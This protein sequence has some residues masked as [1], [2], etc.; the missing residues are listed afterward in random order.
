MRELLAFDGAVRRDTVEGLL[1]TLKQAN[2]PDGVIIRSPGGTFDHFS[3]LGPAIARRGVVMVAADV[4]SAAVALYLLG[5][6]R[7]ALPDATLFFHE[8]RALV[9]P[10][11]EG[12][13]VCDIER[14]LEEEDRIRGED[15]EVYQ[16]WVRQ[17]RMAQNWLIRFLSDYSGVPTSTIV[18]LM[19]NN[20]TLSAREAVH[21]GFVHTIV[22][23][24]ELFLH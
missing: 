24:E 22:T 7:L 4:Q 17:M 6:R 10:G 14:A 23:P 2:P 21:Y 9:A 3:V 16:E 5:S 15:R 19:H 1:T 11:V 8:V 12:V 13:T 18:D 20:A